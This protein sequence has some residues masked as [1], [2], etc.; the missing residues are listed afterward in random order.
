M[1]DLDARIDAQHRQAQAAENEAQALLARIRKVPGC[2]S[3]ARSGRKFGDCP[4]PFSP[5]EGNM[6]VQ[7]L[8]I[9]ADPALASF[10]ANKAGVGLPSRD[11]ELARAAQRE[12]SINSLKAETERLRERN[13]AV[14]ARRQHE[15]QFGRWNNIEGRWV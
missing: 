5:R 12:A 3:W 13:Q 7:G 14:R 9:K 10:L 15:A 2:G 11:A 6:T 1:N 8:I 4:N